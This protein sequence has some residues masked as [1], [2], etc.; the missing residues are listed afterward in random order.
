MS[1]KKF[2]VTIAHTEHGYACR[3]CPIAKT[4]PDTFAETAEEMYLHLCVHLMQGHA[5]P[6]QPFARLAGEAWADRLVDSLP[7][8]ELPA[9]PWLGLDAEAIPFVADEHI[10]EEEEARLATE[11]NAAARARWD[12]L[13]SAAREQGEQN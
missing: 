5:V 1:Q 9:G 13:V 8:G 4:P 11:C 3:G 2:P 12:E 10:G 6:H 7:E